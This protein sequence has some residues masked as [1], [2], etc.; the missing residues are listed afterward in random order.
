MLELLAQ[1]DPLSA[2]LAGLWL[3]AAGMFPVGFMLGG[4]CSQCC[5]PDPCVCAS[6]ERLPE[7]ITVTLDGF[8]DYDSTAHNCIGH[9]MNGKELVLTRVVDANA[10]YCF[11]F[12]VNWPID[13]FEPN[14]K[15]LRQIPFPLLDTS[16]PIPGVPRNDKIVASCVYAH[17]FCGGWTDPFLTPIF[18]QL[19]FIG[20]E[21]QGNREK[22]L[23]VG[24]NGEGNPAVARLA[25]DCG[26]S[27]SAASAS[28]GSINQEWISD[29]PIETCSQFEWSKTNANGV[30]IS[31]APGG[32]YD[33]E[34][35]FG[36]CDPGEGHCTSCNV[37]CQ[38]ES[39]PPVEIEV[40]ITD[41]WTT[42]R[43]AG[44]PD[45]S[46]TYVLPLWWRNYWVFQAGANAPAVDGFSY[47]SLAVSLYPCHESASN[48]FG[49]GATCENCITQCRT[50]FHGVGMQWGLSNRE[51]LP[52]AS[53]DECAE[54][55]DTPIC[56][57]SE[58]SF[59]LLFEGAHVGTA[60]I[61]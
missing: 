50:M 16:P 1:V 19:V 35:R 48:L 4:S 17:R 51:I 12:I 26:F 56:R 9:Y 23:L 53:V 37:C 39:E 60:T 41:E 14:N 45:F 8:E 20:E 32:E 30:S 42:N 55:E 57:P 10:D 2:L 52:A 44:L 38:G 29:T 28:A 46:G 43:P 22:I 11:N 31:V 13:P 33:P 18:S 24:F 36:S 6:G 7:T 58:R 25:D 59:S 5:N 47:F 21:P 15:N 3:F 49:G 54:C 40:E 61:Q 34:S 27:L